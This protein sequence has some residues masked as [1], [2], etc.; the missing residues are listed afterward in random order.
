MQ[1]KPEAIRHFKGAYFFLRNEAPAKV[2]FE[3]TTY[4]TLMHALLG[5]QVVEPEMR[6]KIAA[7]PTVEKAQDIAR[8]SQRVDDAAWGPRSMD[9]YVD[10]LYTKFSDPTLRAKLLATGNRPLVHTNQHGDRFWGVCGGH[11]YNVLGQTLMALR[12][13]LRNEAARQEIKP[14][15]PSIGYLTPAEP[16]TPTIKTYLKRLFSVPA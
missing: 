7:A 3:G 6:A 16:I 8:R 9:V 11:G 14:E 5:A 12:P 4:P 15:A 2:T 1:K 13:K 10:L